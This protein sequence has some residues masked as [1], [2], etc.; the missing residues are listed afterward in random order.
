MWD[1]EDTRML[2]QKQPYIQ[3]VRNSSLV[4]EVCAKMSGLKTTPKLVDR[5]M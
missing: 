1:F 3:R 5:K 2:A 4:E